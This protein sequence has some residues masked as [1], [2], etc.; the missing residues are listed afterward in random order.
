MKDSPLISIITP[1]YNVEHYLSQCIESIMAQTFEEWELIL[2]DDGSTDGSGRICD[3]YAQMDK[4]I[5]VIHKA[6]SGQADSRNIAL[7]A[8]NGKFIGFVDAD[9]WIDKDMYATL[10]RAMKEFGAD[11]AMCGYYRSYTDREDAS[12]NSG[13]T[14]VYSHDRA[15]KLILEDKDIKSFLWDKLFR[16]ELITELM[17][18]SFV[19]EDYAT[20]LKWFDNA[21]RVAFFQSPKYH[22]RLRKGS[23]DHCRVKIVRNYH[24]FLAEKERYDYIHS[25]CLF[26]DEDRN[27]A[28][29]V[30]EVG[31]QEIK[32]IARYGEGARKEEYIKRIIKELYPHLP[33]RYAEIGLKKYIRLWMLLHALPWFLLS[34]QMGKVF[35]DK[36]ISKKEESFYE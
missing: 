9:D 27:Y 10:Y 18:V 7:D 16:K 6:N 34:M 17:P 33:V 3:T 11:I 5:R 35:A 23:T 30:V 24:F 29:K 26:P 12:C 13:K 31:L 8:A 21:Q 32:A 28:V 19:Y 22:Y 1:V 15:L 2:V 25:H 36:R 4:R 14:E 20:V